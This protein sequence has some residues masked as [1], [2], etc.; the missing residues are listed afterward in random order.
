MATKRT[1]LSGRLLRWLLI[2]ALLV[3]AVSVLMILP[4]RWFDPPTTAFILRARMAGEQVEQKWTSWEELGQALPIAVVASE[5]QK[6]PTHHGFDVESMRAALAG[7][8]DR[9]ASTISQQVVKNLYLWPGRSWLRKGIE[10]WLTVALEATLPKR[11][12]LEIY[13]NVAQFGPAIYGARAAT[14]HYFGRAPDRISLDEAARLATVLPSPAK[15]D[16]RH[17]S[18]YVDERAAWILAQVRGLG[19]VAYLDGLD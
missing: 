6:F 12:I 19:G 5:D 17:R 11:R 3:S 10:A 16:L 9:G 14:E 13:L 1:S 15:I 7:G 2:A 8:A 18:E 4:L